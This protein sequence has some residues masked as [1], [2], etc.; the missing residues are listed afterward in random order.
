MSKSSCDF[1]LQEYQQIANA[2]F[3]L[4]DQ[5]NAWFK[6]YV[7][8]LALP[9]TLL[10]AALNFATP[11]G[12]V[13]I[14]QL[15]DV[16]SYLLILVSTLGLF[17]TLSIVSMRMEMILYARTINGVRRYFAILDKEGES[18]AC[19]DG[20]SSQTLSRY[21]IL[22]TTDSRPPFFEPWRAMFWQVIAIGVID[23]L[24]LFVAVRNLTTACWWGSIGIGLA[25]AVFH[26]GT[27]WLMAW[28][29]EKGWELR[30][31]ESLGPSAW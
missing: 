7:S 22:P 11:Q 26:L 21:L 29:R 31:P 17:V 24:V 30:F 5:V 10:T 20:Q 13:S 8:L 1:M 15:P 6:A 23:G 12:I 9:L 19:E 16:V 28:R 3:G 18:T 25:H 14:T 2:Y 4:R 27:Y